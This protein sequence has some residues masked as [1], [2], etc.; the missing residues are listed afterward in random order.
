MQQR[1]R[2]A[3]PHYTITLSVNVGSIAETLKT[4]LPQLVDDTITSQ[5]SVSF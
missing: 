1:Q 5:K 2:A 3:I 4:S